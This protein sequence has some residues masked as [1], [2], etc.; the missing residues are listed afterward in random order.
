[1]YD[2]GVGLEIARVLIFKDIITK[3][4]GVKTPEGR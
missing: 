1:M 2:E 4:S 3:P